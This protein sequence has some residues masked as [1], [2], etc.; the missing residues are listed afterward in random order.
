MKNNA[1]AKTAKVIDTPLDDSDVG[2]MVRLLGDVAHLD[3][4]LNV[5]RRALME[6]LCDLIEAKFWVWSTFRF[7]ENPNNMMTINWL[8][9]RLNESEAAKLGAAASNPNLRSMEE[10]AMNVLIET[11]SHVTRRRRQIVPDDQ[12]WYSHPFNVAHRQGWVDDFIYSYLNVDEEDNIWS[13]IGFHRAW[14]KPAFSPRDSRIVHIIVREVRWLHE[15]SVP[16]SKGER[17]PQLAP[18]LRPVFALLIDGQ[19]RKRIA[20]HLGLSVHTIGD[21][22]KDI[23]KH[24]GV[25]GRMELVR[26]F[27]AGDGGDL[28]KRN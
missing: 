8:H 9:G 24:F 1:I 17:T 19:T 18:R 6:G 13:A 20:H 27:T 25:S 10:E 16:D 28:A 14:G 22:I 23:Y 3:G 26:Y 5:K 15:G 4:G 2:A 11:E 21:Y 12:D 7:D